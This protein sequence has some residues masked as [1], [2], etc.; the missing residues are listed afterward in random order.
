MLELNNII[1]LIGFKSVGKT[2]IGERLAHRL[3]KTWVDTDMLL[4]R[5]LGCDIRESFLRLGESTFREHEIEIF[6]DALNVPKVVIST[7]GGIVEHPHFKELVKTSSCLT[8]HLVLP[9]NEICQR[10]KEKPAFAI[11]IDIYEIYQRRMSLYQN[12]AD[13]EVDVSQSKEHHG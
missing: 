12:I 8:I 11:G 3:N 4:S 1:V 7:G 13:I 10:L 9:W 6:K 5:K 2:T